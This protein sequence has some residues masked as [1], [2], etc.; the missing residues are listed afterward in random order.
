MPNALERDLQK[1]KSRAFEFLDWAGGA[2][3]RYHNTQSKLTAASQAQILP[4][5]RWLMVPPTLWPF[6]IIDVLNHCLDALEQGKDI[7]DETALLIELLSEPP[8]ETDPVATL[9]WK[10]C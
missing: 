5:Y 1:L 8:T 9:G 6:N 2:L 4:L 3:E 10:W 7:P